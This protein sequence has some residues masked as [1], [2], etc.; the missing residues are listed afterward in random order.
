MVFGALD[1]DSLKSMLDLSLREKFLLVP[2]IVLT[3]LFGV[4]P[5]PINDVTAASVS[6]IVSKVEAA[7]D[8]GHLSKTAS[9]AP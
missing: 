7:A 5:K 2:L 3:V 4:W 6:Q 8:F 1:K 9:I